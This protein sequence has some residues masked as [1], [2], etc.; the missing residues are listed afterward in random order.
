MPE[1]RMSRR[2][3]IRTLISTGALGALDAQF[4]ATPADAA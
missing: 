4:T 2:A 1:H 3:M